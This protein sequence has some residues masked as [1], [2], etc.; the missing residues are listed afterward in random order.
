MEAPLLTTSCIPEGWAAY[1]FFRAAEE[2]VE[3]VLCF[4]FVRD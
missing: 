2:Q 3:M 1:K 4:E